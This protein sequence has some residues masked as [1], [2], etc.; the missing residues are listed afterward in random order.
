[1]WDDLRVVPGVLDRPGNND[2]AIRTWQPGGGGTTFYVWGFAASKEGFFTCQLP[3]G[4]LEG[5]DIKMHTHWSPGADGVGENGH[6]VAWKL[7]YSWAN[8]DAAFP[9]SATANMTDACSGTNHLHEL[10]PEVTVSG[11]G[12]TVS[13]M[14]VCRFYRD[15]GDSWVG[16]GNPILLEFDIHIQMDAVGSR[17]SLAK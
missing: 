4:Y 17:T 11:T 13:S 1:M 6:T 7:D 15:S 3:H 8:T 16:S 9:V 12:K 14:L 10:S 5:S 2:P